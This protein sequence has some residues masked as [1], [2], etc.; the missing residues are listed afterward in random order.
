[1]LS[2]AESVDAPFKFW[3]EIYDD[4]E[5]SIVQF[6]CIDDLQHLF[7]INKKFNSMMIK[8]VYNQ[9]YV[10]Q[11]FDSI[12]ILPAIKQAIIVQCFP[13]NNTDENGKVTYND[14]DESSSSDITIG[15]VSSDRGSDNNNN[16]DANDDNDPESKKKAKEEKKKMEEA[17]RKARQE[18]RE[19]KKILQEMTENKEKEIV[20]RVQL[21]QSKNV[22]ISKWF[23]DYL[24]NDTTYLIYNL[25]TCEDLNG[26][27][28]KRDMF[29]KLIVNALKT[30]K[31]FEMNGI[32]QVNRTIVNKRE[33][34]KQE[35]VTE[36]EKEKEKKDKN[37]DVYEQKDNV[38]NDIEMTNDEMIGVDELLSLKFLNLLV[39]FIDEIVPTYWY[40]MAQF[41]SI[42]EQVLMFDHEYRFYFVNIELISTL[43]EFYLQKQS[44]YARYKPDKKYIEMGD[45]LI[46]PKFTPVI[47]IISI[48]VRTC[49]SPITF[50]R[51]NQAIEQ[52]QRINLKPKKADKQ[53]GIDDKNIDEMKDD[54]LQTGQSENPNKEE[55]GK[56][57]DLFALSSDAL[58]YYE[59]EYSFDDFKCFTLLPI[60]NNDTRLPHQRLFWQRMIRHSH[61]DDDIFVY[62]QK[63]FHHWCFHDIIFSHELI[64]LIVEGVDRSDLNRGRT[65]LSMMKK[66]VSINE[67]NGITARQR[68]DKLFNCDNECIGDER[69]DAV[70][71]NQRFGALNNRYKSYAIT[72]DLIDVIEFYKGEHMN[73]GFVCIV[74]IVEC[75]EKYQHFAKLFISI[76]ENRWKNWD[77][78]LKEYCFDGMKYHVYIAFLVLLVVC[79]VHTFVCRAEQNFYVCCKLFF[80]FVEGFGY[81][82]TTEK[83]KELKTF[84][85]RYCDLLKSYG[86][87]VEMSKDLEKG[88]ND[89]NSV[90]ETH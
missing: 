18:K 15:T 54:Q 79:Y 19:Q 6:F 73:F 10:H 34:E 4:I 5:R 44:P 41:W 51:H 30:L 56:I 29:A 60:S 89:V 28:I 37:K 50:E 81:Y 57:I 9:D 59:K 67:D 11:S 85:K 25:L 40:T 47:N 7:V 13:F 52:L 39:S 23:L 62:M 78:W 14:Q 70:N 20:E 90:D 71:L 68:F 77:L 76:R 64:K 66:V 32:M 87:E 69:I 42:F 31:R 24:I 46:S 58:G 63:M 80:L 27:T 12:A 74:H 82:R 8:L 65:Y 43:G 33:E 55:L 45:D 35:K 53:R 2:R 21:I 84:W 72:I 36:K 22:T 83:R 17:N 88:D 61:N 75:A 86:I 16:D 49:H 38:W 1:M 48:L 3:D 26:N